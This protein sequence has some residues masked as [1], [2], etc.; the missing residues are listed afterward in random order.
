MSGRVATC[1]LPALYYLVVHDCSQAHDADMHIILLAHKA[2]VF[3]G[4]GVGDGAV[5][6]TDIQS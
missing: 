3:D 6:A 2:R 5:A 4:F 1:T